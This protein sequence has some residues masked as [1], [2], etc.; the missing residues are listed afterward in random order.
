MGVGEHGQLTKVAVEHVAVAW[1]HQRDPVTSP[2]MTSSILS[3]TTGSKT[4]CAF[5]SPTH[6]GRYCV[7]ERRRY[8]LCNTQVTSLTDKLTLQ[9]QWCYLVQKC[10]PG[11]LSF[12]A[13]QCAQQN[14]IPYKNALNEWLPETLAGKAAI[15]TESL[16]T[17][18]SVRAWNDND[19]VKTVSSSVEQRDN[20][21]WLYLDQNS[22][23]ALRAKEMESALMV[24]VM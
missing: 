13:Q 3:N 22:L 24:N 17:S 2:S 10:P 11:S 9:L 6:G 4:N 15:N 8:S 21:R 16:S 12:R 1:Q 5:L 7:G 20:I 14:N 18:D 23:M 19:Q